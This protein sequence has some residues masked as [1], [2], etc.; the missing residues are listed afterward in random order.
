MST[1]E[2]II[3]AMLDLGEEQGLSN[4]SLSDIALEVGIRKAS[5]YSHFESQQALLDATVLYCRDILKQKSF[6]VDF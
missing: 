1:R 5:I 6:S 2:D 4:V 3:T